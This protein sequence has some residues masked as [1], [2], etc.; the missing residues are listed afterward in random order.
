[1]AVVVVIVVEDDDGL[2]L[3]EES[4]FVMDL[5]SPCQALAMLLSALRAIA[6]WTDRD[7][8]KP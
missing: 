4:L 6:R 3:F 2:C 8:G 7:L 5:T 1:M